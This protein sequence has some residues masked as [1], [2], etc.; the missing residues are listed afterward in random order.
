M[1]NKEFESLLN[2]FTSDSC[3][4]EELVVLSQIADNQLVE[5]LQLE[6]INS[7]LE[8]RLWVRIK[9]R[10]KLNQTKMISK[11]V[12]WSSVAAIIILIGSFLIYRT[13]NESYSNYSKINPTGLYTKNN[14]SF[15]QMVILP[16]GSFVDL[17]KGSSITLDENFGKK[18]R[19]VQL[20]GQAFFKIKRNVKLPFLV[21]I[22]NLVTEVLGTSFRINQSKQ[23]KMIEV[24]V[25]EGK[26]SVYSNEGTSYNKL[27][28]VILT[29][30]QKALFNPE[31]KA[32]QEGLVD[33]PIIIE[34]KSDK[35]ILNFEESSL[36]HVFE[37][38]NKAYGIDII[39]LNPNLGNCVF[40]GDLGGLNMFKQIE[41]ICSATSSNYEVRGASIF[42]KGIGCN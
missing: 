1:T 36:T 25:K 20:I 37:N 11:K 23:N 22:G 32:I 33:K 21:H 35:I 4:Q 8:K 30:N 15:N 18:N 7:N 27:S 17:E 13:Q 28:G 12:V 24:S 10:A 31:T 42:I 38:L 41:L 19:S 9:S 26:V 16:D 39:L 3:S 2:K 29:T 5:S 6:N 34:T 14:S 40:T